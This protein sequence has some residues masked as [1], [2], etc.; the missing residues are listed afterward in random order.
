MQQ[1]GT[2]NLLQQEGRIDLALLAYTR[3]E[4]RSVRRAAAAYNVQF[5]RVSDRL[6][7]IPFRPIVRA[8][9]LK[10]TASEERTIVRDILDL[11]SR[12]FAPRLCEV[13]DKADQLLAVRGG[14]LVG[15]N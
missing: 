10:L 9:G 7:G 11:D 8:N 3:G 12:G 15:K 6:H 5:Q 4:F 13:A 1:Q 2:T 14:T